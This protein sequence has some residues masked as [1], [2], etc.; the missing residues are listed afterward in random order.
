MT[1]D[2]LLETSDSKIRY[3]H[4]CDRGVHFCEDDQ[5]LSHALL[6][7]W[8]IAINTIEKAPEVEFL[9]GKPVEVVTRTTLGV[10]ADHYKNSNDHD[11]DEDEIPF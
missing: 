11:F 8:C 10:P 9:H 1:W 3:C 7:D 5:E 6:N 4:K 2:K